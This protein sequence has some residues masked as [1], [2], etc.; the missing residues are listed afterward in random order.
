MLGIKNYQLL[1]SLGCWLMLSRR[2]CVYNAGLKV[3]VTTEILTVIMISNDKNACLCKRHTVVCRTFCFWRLF[4]P[5]L[6]SRLITMSLELG[7]VLSSP[8]HRLL[9]TVTTVNLVTTYALLVDGYQDAWLWVMRPRKSKAIAS[10]ELLYVFI[11]TN[12]FV[13]WCHNPLELRQLLNPHCRH[14]TFLPTLTN[15]LKIKAI[16]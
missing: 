12:A 9:C 3:E 6:T 14:K 4:R 5:F 7:W 11:W 1:L 10:D 15:T 16:G 2:F 8:L 13:V